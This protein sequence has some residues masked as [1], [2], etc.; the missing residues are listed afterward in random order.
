M[1]LQILNHE[2][3]KIKEKETRL[4]EEPIRIDIIRKVVETEREWHP[5]A[6]TLYAGMNRSA[7]G[8]V[9]RRRHV[10]KSDRGKGMAR[11]PKKAFWRR[12]TQFSW[13]GA[14]V[15]STR[16]GRRAHPPHGNVNIKKINKKESR[17][18]LLSS[19]SYVSS[20]DE[21]KKKYSTLES[22]KINV[23]FPLIVSDLSSL[24]TKQFNSALQTILNEFISVAIQ[25]RKLRAGRGKSRGRKYKTTS[26]LLVV[27]GNNEDKKIR[28]V[29]VKKVSDICVSDFAENG[30]RLTIFSEKAVDDLEQLFFNEPKKIE[31]KTEE[32]RDIRKIR[33]AKKEMKPETQKNVKEKNK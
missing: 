28:G 22:K 18:A 13:A 2:G 30:A 26:G 10:W 11:I 7:S 33:K 23:A 4:F 6:P 14:I 32:R 3:K 27:V 17:K 9:S 20:V 5:N 24:D 25:K 29:E 19:L 21:V 1:K 31:T 8:N 12:G 16:G 15:P